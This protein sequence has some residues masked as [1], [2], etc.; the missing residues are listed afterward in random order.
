MSKKHFV[1]VD[2][3]DAVAV[4]NAIIKKRDAEGIIFY[5]DGADNI[6]IS[7]FSRAAPGLGVTVTGSVEAG[8]SVI[9]TGIAISIFFSTV[10]R[11]PELFCA[12]IRT[13]YCRD[14]L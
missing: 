2:E 9:K 10:S 13:V 7:F 14:S 4:N 3:G 11:Q 1:I 5:S 8:I 12:N 6:F